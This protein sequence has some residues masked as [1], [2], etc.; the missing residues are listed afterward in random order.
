MSNSNQSKETNHKIINTHHKLALAISSAFIAEFTSYPLDLLKTRLQIQG[1]FVRAGSKQKK[2]LGLIKIAIDQIKQDGGVVRLYR[3]LSP[4]LLRHIVYSGVR[5]PLYEYLRDQYK[6][7]QPPPSSN[8]KSKIPPGLKLYQACALAGFSGGLA[9]WL[10]SPTDLLKVR[11]QSG[12]AE[13]LGQ[14]IRQIPN[15]QSCWRG[16]GPNVGR[17]ILVNQGDL[18]T[19]DRVKCYMTRYGYMEEGP[20]LH[21]TSSAMAGFVACCFAT[22]FDTIKV[23]IMNQPIC[24]VTK[25][26]MYYS[27]VFNCIK[28]M[29]AKEGLLTFYRGFFAAWP[30]MALWSQVFWHS[31]ENLRA[32]FN[33]KPF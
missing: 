2:K 22:P 13:T 25:K 15:L 31:N 8:F 29:A 27:G 4:A 21:F 18:M 33:L 9:Q 20:V 16:A 28:I 32:L 23:R 7:P 30:R 26:P 14:A 1:E 11:I 5:M 24:E 3:G 17:A 12:T 10:A 19:Y 6:Q